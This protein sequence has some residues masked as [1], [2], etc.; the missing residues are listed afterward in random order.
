M[1]QEYFTIC[2]LNSLIKDVV[3]AGF[4]RS[5]WVCGEIQNLDRYKS[6]AHL[7][8]DLVEKDDG[9]KD[10]KAKIGVAIWAGM[11]PKI[12]AIL[13]KGENA[14]EL[15]DGIEVKLSGRVE[16]YPPYGTLRFIVDNI[17]PV[18]T[19]GKIAQDRQ[20]LIAELAKA[21]V[22]AKNKA[23]D[24]P[25]VPLRVGLVT[26]FDS[27][28][29]ND[30]I[31]ELQHS[32]FAFKVFFINA[33]MQ[34]KNCEASVVAALKTLNSM[35]GL[36]VLV[37]TRGGGSIAEL[38]AFD[39]KLIALA[40]ADSRYPVLTGI[41]HEINTSVTDLAA[42]TY[43]KTPTAVAQFLSLRVSL[44]LDNLI[45][46][47]TRLTDLVHEKF[48]ND[49]A[50]LKTS[51]VIL[52]SRTHELL[53]SRRE[54]QVRVVERLRNTSSRINVQRKDLD[55]FSESLKKTICLRFVDTR[56]KIN[57]LEKMV[58]L[59]SPVKLFKRGFSVTRGADGK[60]VHLAKSVARGDLLS[61]EFIDG[62]VRSTA[63]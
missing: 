6:K 37:I 31:H 56:N 11:R 62:K 43:A 5:L 47:Y 3:S 54:D 58:E 14:F 35:E 22:F 50:T 41:G 24:M 9:A 34:G 33:V 10:I 52:A 23:H 26:A 46:S 44:F 19:L 15:K 29:Y 39:S 55:C 49:K 16:F 42:H 40:V 60:V 8:F 57:A 27:A 17:D 7:F 48:S 30:F 61:T 25:L 59:S 63:S 32:G 12:E 2:E 1:S 4:P 38:S 45:E 28:A 21:G 53:K 13:K 20:K 18:Y 51:T 36:D